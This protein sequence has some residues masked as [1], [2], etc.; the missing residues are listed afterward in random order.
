MRG[1]A[2]A[3]GTTLL[4]QFLDVVSKELDQM[5]NLG[6]SLLRFNLFVLSKCQLFVLFELLSC[7]LSYE[8]FYSGLILP[9]MPGTKSDILPEWW[10][11]QPLSS[12]G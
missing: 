1:S 4:A 6:T 8:V 7:V 5:C 10:S 12:A 3:D 9:W 11:L 2:A